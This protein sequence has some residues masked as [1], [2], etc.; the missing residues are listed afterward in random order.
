[1]ECKQEGECSGVAGVERGWVGGGHGRAKKE[2]LE[3]QMSGDHCKAKIASCNIRSEM[4]FSFTRSFFCKYPDSCP[5][6]LLLA[7]LQL[8][9]YQRAGMVHGGCLGNH[10]IDSTLRRQTMVNY[11]I[12]SCYSIDYYEYTKP[13][14]VYLVFIK[15]GISYVL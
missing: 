12:K 3:E 2:G 8:R 4:V 13:G 14:I 7:E 1:M 10:G 6:S 9:L 11:K 15:H 5:P